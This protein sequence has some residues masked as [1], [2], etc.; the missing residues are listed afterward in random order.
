MLANMLNLVYMYLLKIKKNMDL[1]FYFFPS[2]K[3]EEKN[4]IFVWV[5]F[6]RLRQ[7]AYWDRASQHSQSK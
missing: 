1:R 7:L 3:C 5:P 4:I 2:H 6:V